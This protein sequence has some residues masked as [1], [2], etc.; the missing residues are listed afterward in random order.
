MTLTLADVEF[1]AAG[2]TTTL[3]LG[4]EA[5]LAL[6]YALA[7]HLVPSTQA[8]PYLTVDEAA[9]YLRAPRHRVYG[10]LSERKL[11]RYKDGSRTLVSREEV[12]AHVAAQ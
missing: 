8:S 11:T 3:T 2:G 4:P 10:L 9:E 5:F 7:E 12:E 6:V 1:A